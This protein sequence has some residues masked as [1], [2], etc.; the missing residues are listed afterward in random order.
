[1]EWKPADQFVKMQNDFEAKEIAVFISDCVLGHYYI[2]ELN[3]K[4]GDLLCWSLVP[5]A[6]DSKITRIP[7]RQVP[8]KIWRQGYHLL[9]E[10]DTRK[11]PAQRSGLKVEALKEASCLVEVYGDGRGLLI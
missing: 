1:M 6:Y 11:T 5:R 9:I 4:G 8:R 2:A 3:R 7:C 10:Q